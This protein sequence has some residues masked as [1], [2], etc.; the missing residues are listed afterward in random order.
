MTF[1]CIKCG[2]EIEE[3]GALLFGP[4]EEDFDGMVMK[5]HLCG[6]CYERVMIFILGDENE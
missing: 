1:D 5:D 2:G 3:P 4:P 6:T